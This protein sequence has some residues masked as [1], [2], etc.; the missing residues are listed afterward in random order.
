[1]LRFAFGFGFASDSRRARML[2]GS[3][4]LTELVDLLEF[5]GQGPDLTVQ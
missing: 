5:G 4:H 2:T 1:M 3:G